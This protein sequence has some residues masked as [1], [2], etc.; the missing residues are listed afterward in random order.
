M[1]GVGWVRGVQ[2]P[3]LNRRKQ[4]K[5]KQC[6]IM[7]NFPSLLVLGGERGHA[8]QW[9]CYSRAPLQIVVCT[10]NRFLMMHWVTSKI[11]G[12]C[13][14]RLWIELPG[15]PTSDGKASTWTVTSH[16]IRKLLA[17]VLPCLSQFTSTKRRPLN[18]PLERAS[19]SN[20][21][22]ILPGWCNLSDIYNISC[23]EIWEIQLSAFRQ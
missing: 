10:K 19:N 1:G 22:M 9:V 14:S 15:T 13:R 16:H 7:S 4:W 20:P 21:I 23:K 6:M 3:A 11:T 18:S 17:P 12:G 5:S 2:G 8:F